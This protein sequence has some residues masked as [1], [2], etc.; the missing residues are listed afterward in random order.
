MVSVGREVE[1]TEGVSEDEDPKYEQSK[2][3]NICVKQAVDWN[4]LSGF[5]GSPWLADAWQSN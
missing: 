1:E 3:I 2:R 5:R 4:W